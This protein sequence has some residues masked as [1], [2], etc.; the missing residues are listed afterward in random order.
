M[1]K[2]CLSPQQQWEQQL[3]ADYYDARYRELLDP[4]YEQFQRWKTSELSHDD[5]AEAIHK[6]HRENQKLYSF[7]TGRRDLLAF[8]IQRQDEEWFEKW[9][10]DHPPPS[11]T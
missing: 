8:T 7:F 6:V 10:V 1:G 9:V 3:V 5:I 4:L 2:K 11:E